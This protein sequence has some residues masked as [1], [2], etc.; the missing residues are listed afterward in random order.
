VV[1][2]KF[3][4]GIY[5]TVPATNSEGEPKQVVEKTPDNLTK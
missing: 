3:N 5:G 2:D 1:G 4:I